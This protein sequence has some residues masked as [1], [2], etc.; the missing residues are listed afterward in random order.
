MSKRHN[1][2]IFTWVNHPLESKFYMFRTVLH[3]DDSQ[4]PKARA[5]VEPMLEYLGLSLIRVQSATLC[6][7]KARVRSR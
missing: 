1:K 3:V 4:P 7:M 2:L 6:L 5:L